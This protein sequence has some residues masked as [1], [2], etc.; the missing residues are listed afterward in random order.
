M[1]IDDDDLIITFE[2]NHHDIGDSLRAHGRAEILKMAEKY[3]DRLIAAKVHFT[4]EGVTT[5]CSVNVQMGGLP[6]I[7]AEASAKG[8]PLAFNQAL[9]KVATQLRRSKRELREDK[10]ERVDKGV[11]PDGSRML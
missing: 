11:L 9:E 3:F 4:G 5:R 10:A 8:L 7:S 1:A 6:M 2:S